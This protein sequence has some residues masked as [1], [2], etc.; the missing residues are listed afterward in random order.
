[1]AWRESFDLSINIR[2]Y[3]KYTVHIGTNAPEEPGVCIVCIKYRGRGFICQLGNH[4]LALHDGNVGWQ[5]LRTQDVNDLTILKRI[6]NNKCGSIY[7]AVEE[8]SANGHETLAPKK[9]II[10]FCDQL[11]DC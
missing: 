11:N 6:L 9:S 5:N 1:M 4:A 10:T 7:R 8:F 3:L 2:S